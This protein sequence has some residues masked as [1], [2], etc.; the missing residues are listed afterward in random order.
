MFDCNFQLNFISED[1]PLEQQPLL[2]YTKVLAEAS[3]TTLCCPGGT[4][5]LLEADLGQKPE[6]SYSFL[7]P[8]YSLKRAC[9]LVMEMSARLEITCAFHSWDLAVK[10]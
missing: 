5:Q 10:F 8:S 6:V 7:P 2:S 3:P 1:S 4:T 9:S